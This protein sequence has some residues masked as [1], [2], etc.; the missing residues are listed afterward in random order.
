LATTMLVL[1][2]LITADAVRRWIEILSGPA[3]LNRPEPVIAS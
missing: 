2:V 3:P 1:T